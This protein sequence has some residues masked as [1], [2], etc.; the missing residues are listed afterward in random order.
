MI[1]F[2]FLRGWE[3]ILLVVIL[4]VLGMG[5]FLPFF[6][7]FWLGVADANPTQIHEKLEPIEIPYHNPSLGPL[8]ENIYKQTSLG[9]KKI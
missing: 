7:I 3:E 8:A 6:L 1:G 9:Y 4:F 2:N 5:T